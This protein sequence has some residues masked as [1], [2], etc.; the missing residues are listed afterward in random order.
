M[1]VLNTLTNALSATALVLEDPALP[2]V[3]SILRQFHALEQKA[4]S[5]TRPG[6]PKP[7]AVPGIGLKRAV[8]PLRA[9]LWIRKNPWSL[10]VGAFAL[11]AIP[12]LL[13]YAAGRRSRSK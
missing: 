9:L 10:P 6:A 3:V 13:G 2:E 7:P 4:P 1:A 11:L 8:P 12:A 5:T